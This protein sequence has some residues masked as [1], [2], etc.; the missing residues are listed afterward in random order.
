MTLLSIVRLA[1][2]EIFLSILAAFSP[3]I[4]NSVILVLLGIAALKIAVMLRYDFDRD[5]HVRFPIEAASMFYE[6]GILLRFLAGHISSIRGLT[7]TLFSAVLGIV[8]G[9]LLCKLLSW[10]KIQTSCDCHPILFLL[11]FIVAGN[12][13]LLLLYLLFRTNKGDASIGFGVFTFQVPELIK[14]KLV[15]TAHFTWEAMQN[16][17]RKAYIWMLY[18]DFIISIALLLKIRETGTCLILLYFALVM[19]F[20]L[21]WK[22]GNVGV[23]KIAAARL[24]CSS[25]FPVVF[26]ILFFA[27]TGVTKRILYQVYPYR[28]ADGEHAYQGLK[29]I[30]KKMVTLST[31]LSGD[32][33]QV[34]GA[35]QTIKHT[36]PI[37]FNFNTKIT[38]PYATSKEAI[39]DFAYVSLV[40]AFGNLIALALLLLFIAALLWAV[41]RRGDMLAKANAA[42]LLL[43]TLVQISGLVFRFCFTGVNIPFL[44]TGGSTAISSFLFLTVLILSIQKNKTGGM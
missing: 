35:C 14:I 6:I 7:A 10:K 8:L 34:T 22:H 33:S 17:K 9:A 37:Q 2:I 23:P 42:M 25:H 40:E 4:P 15:L 29:G 5:T 19:A 30:A 11:V 24:A 13:L 41:W 39:S 27:I 31:R 26:G 16:R 32:S 38:I 21:L 18:A 36:A 12:G 43:Q 3:I 20:L 1:S 28:G 44:S